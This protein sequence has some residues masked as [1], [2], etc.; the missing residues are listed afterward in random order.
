[1]N[2]QSRVGCREADRLGGRERRVVGD[3]VL[4]PQLSDDV[5]GGVLNQTQ[6]GVDLRL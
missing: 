1:M 2:L 4:I 6:S 3:A 5:C